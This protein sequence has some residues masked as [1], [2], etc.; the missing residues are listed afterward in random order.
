MAKGTLRITPRDKGFVL[1]KSRKIQEATVAKT[2]WL[3]DEF[4]ELVNEVSGQ[5]EANKLPLGFEE[6]KHEERTH[7]KRVESSK[8]GY[9]LEPS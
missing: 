7:T 1:N 4:K 6:K 3:K 8:G 2:E 9:D 5:N